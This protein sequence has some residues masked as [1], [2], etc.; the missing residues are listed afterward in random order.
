M[1]EFLKRFCVSF[2]VVN[3]VF[4][5][6]ALFVV[7]RFGIELGFI[8]LSIGTFT[9]TLFVAFSMMLF[10]AHIING[11]VSTVLGFLAVLPVVFIMRRIFGVF[12]FK[13]SFMIYVLSILIAVIYGIAIVILSKKYQND[14]R[15]L[16]EL[17]SKNEDK[18]DH[19]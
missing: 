15:Y 16:N 10:K 4:L 18:N 14:D 6:V 9:V 13:F 5:F 8:R 11:L 1:K 3:I 7:H 17:L 12:I 19:K 2:V